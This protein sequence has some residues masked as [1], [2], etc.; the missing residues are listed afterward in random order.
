M[1]KIGIISLMLFLIA[2]LSYAG[3][4]KD[5]EEKQAYIFGVATSLTDSIAFITEI[6]KVD[7]LMINKNGFIDNEKEYSYQLKQ[8]IINNQTKDEKVCAVFYDSE[9][10]KINKEYKKVITR[11][12]NKDK[13]VVQTISDKNFKFEFYKENDEE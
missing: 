7:S 2:S 5:K 1:K 6:Q 4:K 9:I 3:K 11:L 13:K 12:K 8:Y 10:K